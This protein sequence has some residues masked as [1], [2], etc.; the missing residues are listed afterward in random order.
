MHTPPHH[1]PLLVFCLFLILFSTKAFSQ[2]ADTILKTVGWVNDLENIYTDKQEQKLTRMI[3][4]F[5][6][7]TTVEIA[8]LTLDTSVVSKEN[9]DA[10]ILTVANRWGVGKAGKDNGV[11]I[12]IS[13]GHRYISIQNGYGVEKQLTDAEIK[14]IIDNAFI[15]KFKRGNYYKG[16]KAGL[17]ALMH[18]LKETT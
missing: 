3:S 2:R 8:V 9:F 17:K 15:P 1:K 13:A 11:V 18:E 16:T 6:K 14:Q 5:E 10:H 7:Q 12:G 4:D